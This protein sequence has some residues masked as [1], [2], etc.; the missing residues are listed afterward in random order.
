VPAGSRGIADAAGRTSVAV[1]AALRCAMSVGSADLVGSA[2]FGRALGD[3]QHVWPHA[4]AR[5]GNRLRDAH[6][7]D[8]ALGV[9]AAGPRRGKARAAQARSRGRHARD[10]LGAV[11]AISLAATRAAHAESIGHR[12]AVGTSH[13]HP[14]APR[15]GSRC[16]GSPRAGSAMTGSPRSGSAMTGSPRACDTTAP[17]GVRYSRGA[18]RRGSDVASVASTADYRQP[19]RG[20]CANSGHS[21][22]RPRDR[23]QKP[24]IEHVAALG[25]NVEPALES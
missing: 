5:I 18:V 21:R 19:D 2:T 20:R 4:L 14:D 7:I 25:A 10:A 16:T 15:T 13:N 9:G 8:L 17:A 11:V 22:A 12:R 3:A 24:A 6:L 23:R 1:I